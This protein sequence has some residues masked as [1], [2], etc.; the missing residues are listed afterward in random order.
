ME[1]PFPQRC[2]LPRHYPTATCESP[3]LS[4]LALALAPPPVPTAHWRAPVNS[5]PFQRNNTHRVLL[6]TSCKD[7]GNSPTPQSFFQR[8]VPRAKREPVQLI[9]QSVGPPLPYLRLRTARPIN[10]LIGHRSKTTSS[11]LLIRSHVPFCFLLPGP[12]A[13]AGQKPT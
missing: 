13:E 9:A 12:R 7:R 6:S 11:A 2:A 4:H 3:P 1:R 5:T 8:C 10:R